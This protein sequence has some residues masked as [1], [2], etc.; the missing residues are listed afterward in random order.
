M[1]AHRRE[2]QSGREPGGVRRSGDPLPRDLVLHKKEHRALDEFARQI[3][4]SFV[5][6]LGQRFVAR[7]DPV[8]RHNHADCPG[9]VGVV[10]QDGR[11]PSLGPQP[12]RPLEPGNPPRPVFLPRILVR[13]QNRPVVSGQT[14]AFLSSL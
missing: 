2:A 8:K 10:V 1:A 11:L 3:D 14:K 13:R 9:R 4:H 5:N 6:P 7:H 12:H